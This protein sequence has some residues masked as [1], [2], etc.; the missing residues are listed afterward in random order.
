MFNVEERIGVQAVGKIFTEKLGWI[1][2]EMS[3]VDVGVD[4]IVE[5][6]VGNIPTGKLLAVQIKSGSSYFREKSRSGFLYRGSE[7][8]LSYWLNYSI[9]V[10]IV[11][12]DR[13]NDCAYWQ[14]L[15][16]RYVIKT[17]SAWKIVVPE[18]NDVGMSSY[19]KLYSIA[20]YHDRYLRSLEFLREA[21]TAMVESFEGKY[22]SVLIEIKIEENLGQGVD[23]VSIGLSF[24]RDRLE[25][26]LW[27][28]MEEDNVDY[29]ESFEWSLKTTSDQNL[30]EVVRDRIGWADFYVDGHL[31]CRDVDKEGLV[32]CLYEFER[33]EKEEGDIQQY[34]EFVKSFE[35]L[36]YMQC[37]AQLCD[38]GYVDAE[39]HINEIGKAFVLV[40]NYLLSESHGLCD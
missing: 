31:T 1:F 19:Y 38:G 22:W 26:P 8:K 27:M 12:Y 4:A 14:A 9:P 34:D 30:F 13:R 18:E 3:S 6:A 37:L 5:V 2:R 7:G 36:T 23:R 10:I 29:E 16:L 40:D 33:S 17:K 28:Q 24:C 21:K 15:G 11:L 35:R 25:S 32:R 20:R 39:L